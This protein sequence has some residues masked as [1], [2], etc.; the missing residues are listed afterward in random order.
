MELVFPVVG[1][2]AHPHIHAIVEIVAGERGEDLEDFDDRLED[3]PELQIAGCRT[4]GSRPLEA[5]KLPST[6]ISSLKGPRSTMMR[7]LESAA[8]HL[9]GQ[10]CRRIDAE[11]QLAGGAGVFLYCA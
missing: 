7:M 5:L 4:C 1:G 11:R 3:G 2:V 8:F 9:V 6:H 10:G